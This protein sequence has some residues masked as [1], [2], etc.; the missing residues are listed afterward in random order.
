MTSEAELEAVVDE[1]G[2]L[3]DTRIGLRPQSTL[4]GRLRRSIRDEATASGDDLE[5]YVERLPSSGGLMQSLVNRV[6]VQESGFFRHPDHFEVLAADILP[7]LTPPVTIWSAGCANGQEAYS[8]VMLLEEQGIEGSVLATDLSTSA[9]ERTVAATYDTREITGL[10]TLR[11]R[12]H[13][14]RNIDQWTVSASLR[15]RVAAMQHN[16]LD[17]L[18]ARVPTCQVVFCRNV[19]IYFSPEHTVA[20]L[21]RVAA[22]LTPG[23]YLFLGAAESLWHVT[24]RFE[25]V[26]LGESFV[27]RRRGAPAHR[28]RT[29]PSA[30][31][32]PVRSSSGRQHPTQSQRALRR[33][34]ES[35][36]VEPVHASGNA[37]REIDA[38]A[39]MGRQALD[40]GE[41]AAAVVAFRKW[42]YLAPDDPLAS[43]HLALALEAGGHHVFAQRA[44]GA[45]RAAVHRG[46]ASIEA[47]EL[48]GYSPEELVRLLESKQV[49]EG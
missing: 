22:A 30:T 7:A 36:V 20:F 27:Y 18:P 23:A 16:L 3:L 11:R 41:T 42:A 32:A 2:E 46:G 45:A 15:S 48:G 40:A 21:D 24:D 44:F 35:P 33:R 1:V 17:S 14:T 37:P 39:E 19:L 47:T 10:S 43:L 25:P 12:R 8:L 9:L 29:A 31:R 26:Q 13:L 4:R 38:V 49:R 5:G 28:G 34:P 6:T